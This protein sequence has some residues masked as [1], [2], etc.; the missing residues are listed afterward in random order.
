M[1]RK[2]SIGD[3]YLARPVYLGCLATPGSSIVWKPP[4]EKP[5]LTV[6]DHPLEIKMQT[7]V[8]RHITN[9]AT[10]SRLLQGTPW[11][12]AVPKWC[13]HHCRTPLGRQAL[14]MHIISV[15]AN[16]G[17]MADRGLG[18]W[19]GKPRF[20]QRKRTPLLDATRQRH[21]CTNG[22]LDGCHQPLRG[23]ACSLSGTKSPR[24][25]GMGCQPELRGCPGDFGGF[26]QKQFMLWMEF[27]LL[28]HC[29]WY[30]DCWI[31]STDDNSPEMAL[32]AMCTYNV[33]LILLPL[34]WTAP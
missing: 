31:H 24:E 29:C 7:L 4:H 27:T 14:L 6:A 2:R 3:L 23:L 10:K 1:T 18:P 21:W 20:S 15:A 33:C 9:S 30:I 11:A 16:P 17:S 22:S 12:S 8:T 26:N 19:T 5:M 32:K 34:M 13:Q 28:I 25:E